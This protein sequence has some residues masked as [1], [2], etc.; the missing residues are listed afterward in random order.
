LKNKVTGLQAE[1]KYCKDRIK[2]KHVSSHWAIREKEI[3]QE[4]KQLKTKGA[5]RAKRS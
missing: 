2:E 3:E 4:L 1:L 5:K